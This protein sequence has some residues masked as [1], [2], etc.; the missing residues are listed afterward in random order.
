MTGRIRAEGPLLAPFSG[1]RVAPHHAEAVAAPPYDV[2]S[3][4]EAKAA[5][6]DRPWSFLHVSRPEIDLRPEPPPGAPELYAGAATA[7]SK[8]IEA[9][10]LARDPTPRF[11]AYRMA[12]AAHVQTGLVAAASIA[13]YERGDIKRHELTRPTKENDRVR[14][15][16]ALG[17]QTGPVFL[18]H[19]PDDE[20]CLSISRACE[21]PPICR[22]VL[23][24]AVTHSLWP[25]DDADRIEV[26]AS[27]FDRIGVLY[28]ADG[29]HRA[30]AAARA[31]AEAAATGAPARFLSVSFPADQVQILGYHRIV[32]DLNG[33]SVAAFLSKIGEAVRCEPADAPVEPEER[34]RFGMYVDGRWYRLH[35]GHAPPDHASAIESL[36][37]SILSRLVLEPILG[38]GDPRT[39]PRID[40][41]GGGRGTAALSATVDGGT[42]AVAFSLHP[43][44]VGDLMAVADA[45]AIMPPKSTWFEP[46]LADGLVSLVVA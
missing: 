17:A 21:G 25:I 13:A 6:R 29:H 22:C 28:I 11:Y 33:L 40:F 26:L 34:R 43:P 42:A 20:V 7:F 41:V 1:L 14:H 45:G 4:P 9:G 24:G 16:E 44:A 35:I 3:V 5:A 31:A 19:R 10:V 23:D 39:D 30:A 36:D 37:I 38:I 12:T 27:R 18:V 15:I 2:L 8:M 32:R 46:K